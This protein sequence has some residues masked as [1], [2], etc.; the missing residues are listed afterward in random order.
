MP[1][2]AIFASIILVSLVS[3]I[4]V[5]TLSLQERIL[6]KSLL[7]L[8]SFSVGVLF[9][10]VFFHL[11]P[12]TT[13]R[14][15]FT[16]V[17]GL[18]I[19]AAILLFF[20]LENVINWHHHHH[21]SEGHDV[22]AFGYVNLVGDALHNFLDGILIA[23]SYLVSFPL[24]IATTVAVLLHEIPQE[25][26]DFGVLIHSGFSVKKA[27]QF[28]FFSALTAILGGIVG[29]VF[30]TQFE[31]FSAILIPFT[32]GSFIYIAGTDLLPEVKRKHGKDMFL[33]Q[34]LAIAAGMLAM[35]GLLLLGL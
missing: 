7:L 26:G 19:L 30:V 29:L 20:I 23:G 35:Y 21:Y 9:G 31:W 5:F 18:S 8:V 32:A 25:I 4:G 17:T 11:L 2:I 1:V 13:A 12:E 24:G 15:G 6:K 28:N 3:L 27:I 33:F 34:F 14:F 16:V 22:H 10:D